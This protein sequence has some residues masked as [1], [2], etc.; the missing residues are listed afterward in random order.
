MILSLVRRLALTAAVVLLAACS[1]DSKQLPADSPFR[2]TRS[3]RELRL[4]AEELYRLARRSLDSADFPSALQR[5]TQLQLRFPFTEFATQAQLESIY[6]RYRSFDP[7]GALSAADRFLREHPRHPAVDYVHYLKGMTNF[8]RGESM[9]DWL[10][11]PTRQDM[12]FSRRA[13]DDFS[14]L[15]Q[16]YPDSPYAGDARQ[17]M[18][19]LR[20]RIAE[21]ELHVVRYYIRRGAYVAAAKRA[22]NILSEYPGAPARTEALALLE[23]SYRSLG[24]EE[25]AGDVQRLIQANPVPVE[26]VAQADAIEPPRL[27]RRSGPPR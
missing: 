17:R 26:A 20:N 18:I 24:L 16:K 10:T 7:D 22:E 9:F 21:H 2:E 1:S 23:Q 19:Y 13:F 12:A 11:D 27:P 15:V 8:Q 5:Y 3:E 4:E 25:Q 14:L 6:A